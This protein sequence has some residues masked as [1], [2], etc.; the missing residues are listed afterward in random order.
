MLSFSQSFDSDALGKCFLFK[1]IQRLL[2]Y[3]LCTESKIII[4]VV[5]E[6]I[7]KT[8]RSK[9]IFKGKLVKQ[10]ILIALFY[11]IKYLCESVFSGPKLT[12]YLFITVDNG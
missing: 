2:S 7:R 4:S 10:N 5:S 11:T 3:W 8:L 6:V 12:P 9:Y 1:K